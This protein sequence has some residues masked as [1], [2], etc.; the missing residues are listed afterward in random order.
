MTSEKLAQA[1]KISNQILELDSMILYAKTQECEL[2]QF[3]CPSDATYAG[4]CNDENI[5]KLVRDLIIKETQR[6]LSKLKEDFINL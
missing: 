1:F 6:K 4:V 3:T 2:I 5:I